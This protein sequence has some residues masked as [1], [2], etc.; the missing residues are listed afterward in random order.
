[1][2]FKILALSLI[3]VLVAGIF[4]QVALGQELEPSGTSVTFG[5]ASWP[6][7]IIRTHVIKQIIEPLGYRVETVYPSLPVLFKG[8]STGDVDVFVS[9][10]S[11]LHDPQI[12]SYIEEGSIIRAPDTNIDDAR[13]QLV[14]PGYVE[15]DSLAQLG[16][17]EDKFD[18]TVITPAPGT[19]CHLTAKKMIEEDIYGMGDWKVMAVASTSMMLS[20]VKA[21]VEKKEWVVFCGWKPHYMNILFNLKYPDDPLKI[22]GRESRVYTVVR[23]GL[24]KECPNLWKFLTQFKT[25]SPTLN[26]WLYEYTYKERD[27]DEVALEW[28]KEHMGIVDQW[29][30]G[31]R[32]LKTG[33]LGR[34]VLREAIGIGE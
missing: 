11:P 33:K 7:P 22:Y 25:T 2:K 13:L 23:A 29:L 28:I 24:P 18:R 26:E 34:V 27:P 17:Y 4:Q 3:L 12:L 31:V 32:D 16:E 10:W 8:I 30:W 9:Y 6:A 19:G 5:F 14:V 20:A 1:M 15:I 21:K